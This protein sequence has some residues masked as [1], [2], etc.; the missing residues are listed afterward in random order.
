MHFQLYCQ[1]GMNDSQGSNRAR[2]PANTGTSAGGFSFFCTALWGLGWGL[3]RRFLMPS[4][5]DVNMID[6]DDDV[7]MQQQQINVLVFQCRAGLSLKSIRA[8]L[9]C[10]L[11]LIIGN[12]YPSRPTSSKA[13]KLGHIHLAK[14]LVKAAPCARRTTLLNMLGVL[15]SLFVTMYWRHSLYRKTKA[16]VDQ[17]S[18][19]VWFRR[20]RRRRR[21]WL[22]R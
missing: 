17:A 14:S 1:A 11:S 5:Q 16:L 3:M 10:F 19:V 7:M 22:R 9:A 8:C 21:W 4:Y 12:K 18:F 13:H 15:Y 20:R 2:G 6:R